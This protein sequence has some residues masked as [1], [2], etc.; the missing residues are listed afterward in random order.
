MKPDISILLLEGCGKKQS[1]S[2]VSSTKC[3]PY[4][5]IMKK[6]L[7]RGLLNF[8]IDISIG[9]LKTEKKNKH[10]HNEFVH[11]YSNMAPLM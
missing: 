2:S 6:I 4:I 8:A 9:S 10:A 1:F 3:W 7:L 5:W 11:M